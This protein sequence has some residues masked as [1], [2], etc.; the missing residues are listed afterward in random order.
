MDQIN[1]I[2]ALYLISIIIFEARAEILT[3][4]GLLFGRFEDTKIS[5]WDKL[6]FSLQCFEMYVVVQISPWP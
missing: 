6:T 2:K 1:K 5:F 3:K 4:K